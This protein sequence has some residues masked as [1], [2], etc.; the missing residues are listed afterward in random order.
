VNPGRRALLGTLFVAVLA[1]AAIGTAAAIPLLSGE[2][3][4]EVAFLDEFFEGGPGDSGPVRVNVE[5]TLNEAG[6]LGVLQ[7]THF[8]GGSD[9]TVTLPRPCPDGPVPAYGCANGFTVDGHGTTDVTERAARGEI[10]VPS[11]AMVGYRYHSGVRVWSD[12]AVLDWP[13]V[14]S[15]FGGTPDD[16]VEV[17]IRL[18]L[19]GRPSPARIEPHL[20]AASSDRTVR[21]EGTPPVIMGHT[22]AGAFID[23]Q[24]HVAFPPGLVPDAPPIARSNIEG[25]TGF[26]ITVQAREIASDAQAGAFGAGE[27]ATTVT[28]EIR[29]AANRVIATLALGIP[30]LLWLVVLGMAIAR[31]R[32]LSEPLPPLEAYEAEPPSEH[33]PSVVAALMAS[34]KPGTE[35]VAGSILDLAD[36]KAIEIQDLAGEA[37]TLRVTETAVPVTPGESLL[38]ETLRTFQFESGTDGRIAAPPLWKRPVGLWRSFRR[39]AVERA[40]R[41]GLLEGVLSTK[42]ALAAIVLTALGMAVLYAP[43]NPAA[44]FTA[45]IVL[46]IVA[47]IA[48]LRIGYTPT[49]PGRVLQA[50]WAAYGRHLKERTGMR[51]APPAGV[52]IWGKQLAYGAVLGV[53]PTSVRLLA[54]P[55]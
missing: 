30:A 40:E 43:V 9:G 37:F 23:V 10:T 51:D 15:S 38:L 36:R 45:G 19:P 26:D 31:L 48:T 24:L 50:R 11:G 46:V 41:E 29:K 49:L 12:I 47:V 42:L 35:A 18:Q 21:I 14:P 27:V 53:A 8:S 32:R 52:V 22:V 1:V 2:G 44:Y 3:L 39:D 33:D 13:A 16:L 7:Q 54:P 6:V 34:G 28:G 17:S 55:E 4:P 25:R 20:H 5:A